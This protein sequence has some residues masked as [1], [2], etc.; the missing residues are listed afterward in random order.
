MSTYANGDTYNASVNYYEN[1]NIVKEEM[2]GISFANGDKSETAV[3]Y[4]TNGE[5]TRGELFNFFSKSDQKT[6]KEVAAT[7]EKNHVTLYSEGE[8]Y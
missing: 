4:Y 5:K 6:Y 1:S 3:S 8:F 7:Y 2:K